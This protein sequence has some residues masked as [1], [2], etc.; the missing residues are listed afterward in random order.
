VTI[1]ASIPPVSSS[2]LFVQAVKTLIIVTFL[3]T[4][5]R[6]LGKREM[7]Q[8]N[9][10]DLAMLFALSNA[11]QNAMTGGKGNLAVGLVTSSTVIVSTW[12][13][14]RI[15]ARR[16]SLEGRVIGWPTLLVHD[17]QVLTDRMRRARV[18][19]DEL[20]EAL[21]SHGLQDPRQAA[22]VVLEVDGSLSVVPAAGQAAGASSS[23]R[24]GP[25]DKPRRNRWRR[26]SRG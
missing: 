2:D 21:R 14:I 9:V 10:Y 15:L 25:A 3:I 26:R 1:V 24:S 8:L 6:L 16:Q 11:V 22:M 13:L 20:A 17:G 5:F 7:A 23:S 19:D 4:G 12:A 18:T